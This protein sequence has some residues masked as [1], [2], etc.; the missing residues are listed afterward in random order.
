[1]HLYN[2]YKDL[3]VFQKSYKLALEIFEI[4]KG[5]PKEELF[6]LTD[7][8]RRSSRAIPANIG[9]AWVKRKY[10]KSF[11]SKLLD[12]LE[13][14]AETEIW[15]YLSRDHKYIDTETHKRLT[16][17]YNEVAWMLQSMI[18]SPDKFCHQ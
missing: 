1:M 18:H 2:G 16:D 5:F 3:I 7:Q 12:F 15:F 8:V 14:E 13:E 4:T 11:V 17:S 10:P 6:A 9:A